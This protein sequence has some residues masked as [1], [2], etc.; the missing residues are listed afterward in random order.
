MTT[1][2]QLEREAEQTRSQIAETLE[3][4]RTRMTP[5]QVVDQL[6]DYARD[7]S[8]GQF[9][10]NLRQQAMDNPI[11]LT[12]IGAG[13][14]WLM[15]A[16]RK[17]DGLATHARYPVEAGRFGETK[18]ETAESLKEA[19]STWSD[20]T[21]SAAAD[22]GNSVRAAGSRLRDAAVGAA[23][24]SGNAA[25]SAYEAATEGADRASAAVSSAA[26]SVRSG[27]SDMRE[28]FREQPLVLVGI[29]LALGAALGSALPSTET[30]DKLMGG[31]SDKLKDDAQQFAEQQYERGKAVVERAYDA[32]TSESER[33]GLTQGGAVSNS[34]R[35]ATAQWQSAE[36]ASIVPESEGDKTDPQN[37][38][39]RA[40]ERMHDGG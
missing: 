18:H 14:A 4:L 2:A 24:A 10:H 17:G 8:G 35:T 36:E 3:E 40:P 12:L 22:A 11:P 5:G 34:G 1:N 39:L 15:V 38:E 31:R 16:G 28:F 25:S 27:A 29:G 21:R 37:E 30:E 19:A 13:L 7:S 23:A 6:V 9:F 33:D 20:R 26:A 32:G